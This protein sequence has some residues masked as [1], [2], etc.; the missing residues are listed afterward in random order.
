MRTYTKNRRRT[1]LRLESLEGKTLLSAGPA[2]RHVAPEARPAQ[3]AQPP[4]PFSGTLMGPYSNLH[5]PYAGYLLNYATSG[6]L[7]GVGPAHLRGS[8]FLRRLTP[9]P[10]R[11]IGRLVMHNGGGS[12]TLRV[13]QTSSST[14]TYTVGHA[15][16]SDTAYQGAS[17]TLM[18]TL[19]PTYRAPYYVSGQATMTFS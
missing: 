18:I 10:G 11:L 4:A 12:M 17:G 9:R 1:E 19:N 7:T 15:S 14:N 2:M 6:T 13:F 5:I 16:G 8:L 3:I